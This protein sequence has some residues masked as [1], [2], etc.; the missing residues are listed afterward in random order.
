MQAA[1]SPPSSSKVWRRDAVAP[2][3]RRLRPM[4]SARIRTRELIG[5][6]EIE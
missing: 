1:F 3:S 6:G 5:T 4:S 2:P